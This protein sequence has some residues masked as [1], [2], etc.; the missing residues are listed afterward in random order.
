MT[1]PAPSFVDLTRTYV[2]RLNLILIT[3]A[4]ALAAVACEGRPKLD[5][6]LAGK[7]IAG[8]RPMSEPFKPADMGLTEP[9]GGSPF[10]ESHRKLFSVDG[11]AM[12]G[13]GTQATVDF[14]GIWLGGPM[15][16]TEN[17]FRGQ[18]LFRLYDDGWRLD[19]ELL[20]RSLS[21]HERG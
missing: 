7:I 19:E 5:R 20:R 13:D 12:S 18:A 8:A 9:P 1:T 15:E 4:L 11:I 6:D 16:D 14:K 21:R 2:T 17:L 3:T 10:P